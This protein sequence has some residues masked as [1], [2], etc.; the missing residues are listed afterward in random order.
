MAGDKKEKDEKAIIV[1][2][3]TKNFEVTEKKKGLS[4]SISSLFSPQKKTVRA[5]RN[6]SFTINP[7]ELVGFIGPNGAGKTTTLKILS[8]LLYPTAGFVQVLG[9]DPWDRKADF[10]KEIAVVFGQKNQL[11]WDLPA[12]ETFEL[13]R[14]IYEIPDKVY[15]EALAELVGILEVKKLLKTQVRRLSLGQRMRLELVAALLH[16]PDVLFLDEPTIGLDVVA[17]QKVRDFLYEYNKRRKATILLT[18]HN[19]DDLVDLAKRVIVID[20]GKILFDGELTELVGEFAREKIIKVYLSKE[21][22]MKKFE[23]IGEVR[24][25]NY[26][27]VILSVPREAAALAAAELLQNFSVADLTIEEESVESIIRRVFKG[28]LKKGEKRS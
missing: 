20:K 10:L 23:E 27:L 13:N 11:W 5:L 18:S 12:Q 15:K 14:A 4:G 16:R 22:D 6:I 3:L 24:K 9:Y 19:M 17:Q 1:E 25:I 2:H 8:G 7:G 28:E 21:G 26:P